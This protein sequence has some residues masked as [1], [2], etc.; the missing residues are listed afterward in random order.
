MKHLWKSNRIQI[1]LAPFEPLASNAW[2]MA[3]AEAEN[4]GR[5]L[6]TELEVLHAGEAT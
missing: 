3:K 6:N 5:F 4:L 1:T 2:N